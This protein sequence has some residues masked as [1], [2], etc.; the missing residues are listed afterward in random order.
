MKIG[1]ARLST[2]E[3]NLTRNST[4]SKLPGANLSMRITAFPGPLR[5]ERTTPPREE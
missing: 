3:Q 5:S 2:D 1:F 4:L